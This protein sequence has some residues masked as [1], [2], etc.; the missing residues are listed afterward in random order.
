MSGD[1]AFVRLPYMTTPILGKDI[2]EQE[3]TY[4]FYHLQV[5]SSYSL[6]TLD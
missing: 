1:R 3:D 5:C 4:N 2:S 6:M